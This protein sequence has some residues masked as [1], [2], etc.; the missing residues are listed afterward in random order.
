MSGKIT[1]LRCTISKD[2]FATCKLCG[3]KWRLTNPNTRKCREC[4]HIVIPQGYNPYRCHPGCG[5]GL[6]AYLTLDW[7]VCRSSWTPVPT[8]KGIQWRTHEAVPTNT[9]DLMTRFQVGKWPAMMFWQRAQKEK[10]LIRVREI[11]KPDAGIHQFKHDAYF[12]NRDKMWRKPKWRA[13][14]P[15]FIQYYPTAEGL[16]IFQQRFPDQFQQIDGTVAWNP[17]YTDAKDVVLKPTVR[18]VPWTAEEKRAYVEKLSGA[19]TDR[20]VGKA[21]HLGM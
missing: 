12:Y 2:G 20:R 18:I 6:C 19:A 3:N 9:H 11:V 7:I 21:K 17:I 13:T 1:E 4:G 8:M 15:T 16:S 14:R 10:W 5:R